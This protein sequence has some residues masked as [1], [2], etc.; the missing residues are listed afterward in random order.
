M[1]FCLLLTSLLFEAG[2]ISI[3]QCR[4]MIRLLPKP[5]RN[6]LFLSSWRPITLLNVDYKLITK[7]F[8]TRLS[9]FLPDLIHPDQKGFI[10][11]RSIHENLIDIQSLIQESENSNMESMLILLD[12]HKAFDSIGWNFLKSV[13]IQYGFP[14]Y[15][16]TWFDIFYTGKELHILNNGHISEVIFPERGM[17]QG[18]SIS[19]LYFVLALEVLAIAI[20]ENEKIVGIPMGST[21][22]KL[23]LLA[24]DAL[25]ALKWTSE[26][27]KEVVNTL[28]EFADVSNL[29]MK[30]NRL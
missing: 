22:K 19:P 29:A 27:F 28:H 1:I 18:C 3:S 10:K 13:L 7:L 23:N 14:E 9:Q 15:F 11:T 8:A 12:I 5:H 20:R 26:T 25:L 24:D 4:G 30:T 2:R 16:V 6:L 21:C 17:A